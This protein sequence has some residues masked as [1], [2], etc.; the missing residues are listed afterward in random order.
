MKPVNELDVFVVTYWPRSDQIERL[1]A[2]L[3]ADAAQHRLHVHLWDNSCDPEAAR[4]LTPLVARY[5]REFVELNVHYGDRNL[6]FG[7]ANNR[8]LERS[9]QDFV[10]LLNPDAALTP[11]ALARVLAT[12]PQNDDVAAFEFRQ[13]PYEHPKDYHPATLMTT[14]VSGAAVVL[15]RTALAQ[16]GGFDARLFLYGEDVDLSW[17]LRAAGWKLRYVPEA[18]A[19]H[20]SYAAPNQIK[21]AQTLGSTFANL[22]LRLR[23]GSRREVWTGVKML[24]DEVLAPPSFPGR[25]R[26]LIKNFLRFLKHYRHF[27]RTRVAP[28]ESFAPIFSG[29]DYEHRRKGAFLEVADAARFPSQPRVSILIRTHRRAEFLREAI[30][31]AARQTYRNIEI[32]IIEDGEPTAQAM[33]EREFGHLP[34]LHYRATG[35]PVGRALAGNLALQTATGEWCN[36][37]DDDDLLYPDHVETLLA[38]AYRESV[39][40]VYG[41][42]WEV[43]TEVLNQAP[44]QYREAAPVH[45]YQMP[46]NHLTLWVHNYIPIQCLLFRRELYLRYGGFEADMD[47]LEDWNLWTRY[48]LA[49]RFALVDKTTSLYRVPMSPDVSRSRQLALDEAYSDALR[50]QAAMHVSLDPRSLVQALKATTVVERPQPPVSVR[51][52]ILNRFTPTR[53]ALQVRDRIVGYR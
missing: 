53:W 48:T 38:S 30:L 52:R 50:R 40:G 27:A 35:K 36:F 14:W 2:S 47:Q 21:P 29:W 39:P 3:A 1:F 4:R 45:R 7:V 11:G 23:Y 26:G 46:F 31:S 42:G 10:L 32:I 22:C 34:N 44:L 20:D 37:L 51:R 13:T 28:T 5:Q 17:R 8:L 19:V 15:R 12:I 9:Q 33:V 6:G 18:L 41:I 25:R 49:D 16:I 24:F 43:P